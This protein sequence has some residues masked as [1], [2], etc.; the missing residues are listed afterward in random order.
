[1][2]RPLVVVA[3]LWKPVYDGMNKKQWEEH[4]AKKV[5]A[6]IEIE[7]K[8]GIELIC[9]KN[10]KMLA[11][12]AVHSI[13]NSPVFKRNNHFNLRL[14]PTFQRDQGQEETVKFLSSLHRHQQFQLK[15]LSTII[16]DHQ[17]LDVCV[18]LP[19]AEL[20]DTTMD[21]S[22]TAAQ[23]RQAPTARHLLMQIK[24]DGMPKFG[25][26]P[27]VG[28]SCFSSEIVASYP[29]I[30]QTE[31]RFKMANVAAYLYFNHGEQ[32]LVFF[33]SH[34]QLQVK[35]QGWNNKEDRP[36]TTGEER[37]DAALRDYDEDSPMNVIFDFSQMEKSDGNADLTSHP[38]EEG[39]P[40]KT[41]SW[42]RF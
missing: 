28:V 11:R 25:L 4:W 30:W 37:L 36:V 20:Q 12:A 10:D 34:T 31:A 33:P 29:T 6:D 5:E 21:D 16:L 41:A 7:Q 42:K 39:Q 22:T 24:K 38:N 13:I 9:E 18:S 17:S 27:D 35:A 32:G 15:M 40:E 26:L 2:N 23:D 8:W 3:F 19:D 14:V 1:V